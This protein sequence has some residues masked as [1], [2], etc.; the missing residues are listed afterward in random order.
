MNE[1]HRELIEAGD[2]NGLLRAADGLCAARSWEEIVDLAE[3]CEHALERGKQLWPIAAHIDYRVALEAPADYAAGVL[4]PDVGRFAHGPLTEVAA[5]T[6]TWAEIGPLIE[7]PQ[8]ACYV[9][10]ERVLRGEVVIGDPSAHLEILELPGVLVD[11]EPAYSLATYRS[12]HVEVQ[13]PWPP[14]GPLEVIE[15]KPGAELDESEMTQTLLDLVHP[16]TAESNGA[17]RAVVVEGGALDAIGV[18]ALDEA[19]V[20]E[21]TPA[22]AVNRLAW[23]A[24]SGGAHGR[25]RGAALGR[26]MAWYLG[27]LL[28]DL[29]WPPDPAVLGGELGRLR[30]YVWDEG[31]PEEGWT[32]RIGVED[33][34]NKWGAAIGATDL[35]AED[36]DVEGG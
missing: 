8:L 25:R 27:T 30:W 36:E 21:I 12:D 14:E 20:A 13:E 1:H 32:L 11:W 10:Q 26:S 24:A 6:H 19:R 17:A 18:L 5:S 16:W 29:A 2:L 28:C 35:L 34:D 33:P 15:V 7:E 9:A 22:I 3:A 23:A 4:H 31:A